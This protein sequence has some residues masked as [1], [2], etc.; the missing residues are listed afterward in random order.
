LIS[1][2]GSG[3]CSIRSA[4][5]YDGSEKNGFMMGSAARDGPDVSASASC[6]SPE[7][8]RAS[9]AT[10]PSLSRFD[11]SAS[12]GIHRKKSMCKVIAFWSH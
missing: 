2:G 11:K 5:G 6:A 10:G 8:C 9:S 12:A 7:S 1:T 3:S 4:A